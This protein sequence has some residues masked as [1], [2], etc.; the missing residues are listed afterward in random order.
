MCLSNQKHLRWKKERPKTKIGL[1]EKDVKSN[2]WPGPPGFDRFKVLVMT[3]S[4]QKIVISGAQCLLMLM[5]SKSTK[6]YQNLKSCLSV[7]IFGTLINQQ[8]VQWSKWD[9]LK[10]KAVS[11]RNTKFILQVY[12]THRSLTG[13]CK[14]WR[15]KE[16]LTRKA[17]VEFYDVCSIREYRIKVAET[18]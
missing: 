1:A 6:I 16:Q 12:R 9:L 11:L 5:G 2:E 7:C 15:C 18:Y 8:S 14:R 3:T 4:L 13:V 17:C 10:M